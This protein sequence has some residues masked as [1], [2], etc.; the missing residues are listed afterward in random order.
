MCGIERNNYMVLIATAP[1]LL[2]CSLQE[3]VDCAER[4][5]TR[6]MLVTDARLKP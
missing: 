6:P 1:M 5:H 4:D 2:S 3:L